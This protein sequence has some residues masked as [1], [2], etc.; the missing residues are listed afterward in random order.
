MKP[1]GF[2][3]FEPAAFAPGAAEAVA[4]DSIRA[5]EAFNRPNAKTHTGVWRDLAVRKRKTEVDP[6]IGAIGALARE[7]GIPTPAALSAG[8]ELAAADRPLRPDRQSGRLL[9]LVGLRRRRRLLHPRRQADARGA[10]DGGGRRA[11]WMFTHSA[12]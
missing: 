2:N 9:G 8:D 7:E 3:G 1:R 10:G 4:I 12:E 5:M 11:A 6:Q